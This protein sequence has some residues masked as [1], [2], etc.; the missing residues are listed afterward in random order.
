[1]F[2]PPQA[3]KQPAR[4]LVTLVGEQ[5]EQLE[6]PSSVPPGGLPTSAVSHNVQ[7]VTLL[8]CTTYIFC[9]FQNV[10]TY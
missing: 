3:E 2:L 4:L 5:R 6:L 8:V 7:L 10:H 1:M 9:I